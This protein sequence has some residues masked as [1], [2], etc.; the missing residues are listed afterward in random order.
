MEFLYSIKS[1][2]S[3]NPSDTQSTL[4]IN[5][6]NLSLNRTYWFRLRN[7]NTMCKKKYYPEV[8]SK[9]KDGYFN[10][11]SKHRAHRLIK[12]N[13][14]DYNLCMEEIQYNKGRKGL[15]NNVN[16]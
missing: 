6:V 4:I 12:A 15:W 9:M 13:I 1:W 14:K 2:L 16:R 7:E 5:M 8:K 10:R 11:L 3:S